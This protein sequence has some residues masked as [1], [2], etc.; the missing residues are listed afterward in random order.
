MTFIC[1]VDSRS[2]TILIY[3]VLVPGTHFHARPITIQSI[4]LVLCKLN[5]VSRHHIVDVAIERV[6]FS[7]PTHIFSCEYKMQH[8]PAWIQEAQSQLIHQFDTLS[9]NEPNDTNVWASVP[10]AYVPPHTLTIQSVHE[11]TRA[12]KLCEYWCVTKMPP[13]IREYCWDH[14][15][16]LKIEDLLHISPCWKRQ[17]ELLFVNL[18]DMT[19]MTQAI[20]ADEMDFARWFHTKMM[21]SDNDRV[22]EDFVYR[23]CK[24]KDFSMMKWLQKQGYYVDA[25]TIVHAVHLDRRD[26]IRWCIVNRAPITTWVVD[27]AVKER[28]VSLAKWLVQLGCPM[29]MA[30]QYARQNNDL[31]LAQWLRS[32]DRP[33]TQNRPKEAQRIRN[34]VLTEIN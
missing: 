34:N 20:D 13:E 18:H 24:R 12:L 7:S 10:D 4:E 30:I 23:A 33:P 8:V 16:E 1:I 27:M 5:F 22:L 28:K 11:L 17:F 2:Q 31:D 19:R 25:W 21:L 32:K 26:M 15:Q 14:K 9:I 6:E 3:I 29:H